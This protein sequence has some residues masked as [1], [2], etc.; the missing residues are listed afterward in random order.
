MPEEADGQVLGEAFLVPPQER[1]IASGE[2]KERAWS[3]E[4]S[5]EVLD[6]LR[7]MGYLD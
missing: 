2:K 5:Q 4:G 1:R 3:E 7:G 6:R